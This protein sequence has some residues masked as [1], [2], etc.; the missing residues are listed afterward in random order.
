MGQPA[1]GEWRVFSFL[2]H[3]F[4]LLFGVLFGGWD[5]VWIDTGEHEA[6]EKCKG[7]IELLRAY[8]G[9]IELFC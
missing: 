4:F 5:V 6:V 7:S 1:R 2:P 3:C 8:I 9:S